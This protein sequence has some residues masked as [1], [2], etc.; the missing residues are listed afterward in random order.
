MNELA[1]RADCADLF[2]GSKLPGQ[3]L[4]DNAG[5]IAIALGCR[6][7]L[8]AIHYEVVAGAANAPRRPLWYEGDE[9]AA[10]FAPTADRAPR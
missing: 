2:H 7:A 5:G 10:V 4:V 3:D 1:V 9:L 8:G 6:R